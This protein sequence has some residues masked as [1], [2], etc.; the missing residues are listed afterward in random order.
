[1]PQRRAIS[2]PQPGRPGER[3]AAIATRSFPSTAPGEGRPPEFAGAGQP[4][5][6]SRGGACGHEMEGA[7]PAPP[8][9][10]LL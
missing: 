6:L 3:E 10:P 2:A 7:G 5:V 8:R 1:M 4:A 9:L